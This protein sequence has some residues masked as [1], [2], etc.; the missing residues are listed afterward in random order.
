MRRTLICIILAVIFP[1]IDAPGQNRAAIDSLLRCLRTSS[2]DT[3]RVKIFLDLYYEFHRSNLDTAMEYAKKGKSLAEELGF[4]R[5]LSNATY[6]LGAGYNNLRN[7][8]L[9]ENEFLQVVKYAELLQ[10]TIELSVAYSGLA[11]VYLGK[12]EFDQAASAYLHALK[13]LSTTD[14]RNSQAR[15]LNELGSLYKKQLQFDKALTYYED[16]LHI[17]RDLKFQPGISSCLLNIGSVYIDLKE[18]QKALPYLTESLKIKKETGDRLGEGRC[19][20]NI[21]NL[22]R[23]LRNFELAHKLYTESL[24]LLEAVINPQEI[25]RVQYNLSLNEVQRGDFE[26][27]L[28]YGKAGLAQ[29][30]VNRDLD[31]NIKCRTLLADTYA[32]LNKTD[33]AYEHARM[34]KILSDSLY[35]EKIIELSTELDAKYQNEKKQKE[36]VDL[37]SKNQ[38]NAL[39]LQK[40][41]NE[42]NYLIVLTLLAIFLGFVIWSRYRIKV[43]S[44]EKLKELD[45]AKSHFFANI[46]HEFRTPLTLILGSAKD[47]LLRSKSDE[48]YSGLVTLQRNASRLQQLIEQLL[49]LSKL[50]GN[51]LKLNVEPSN[52]GNFLRAITSSFTSW[53]AQKNIRLNIHVPQE[54][55]IAYFDQDI[56]EKIVYNLLSNA[57]KFTPEH[58]QVSLSASWTTVALHIRITDSGPGIPPATKERIFERF[59][60]LDDSNT[61]MQEGSGIGLAL[62]KELVSLHHGQVLVESERG[63][64]ATFLITI[65]IQE[66]EYSP[67]ESALVHHEN[68]GIPVLMESNSAQTYPKNLEPAAENPIILIVED[69]IDLSHFIGDHLPEYSIILAG[70]GVDGLKK[71]IQHVPDLII[72]DV[73]MPEMDGVELCQRLKEEEKTS[74]IPVILLTAKADIDSRMEGLVTGA[75]DYMTKPF[76]ARE[77]QIRVANLIHQREKLRARFSRTVV[78]KPKDIAITPPD[79]GFLAKV[80][81]IIENHLSDSEFTVEEFQKEVGMSRMQLHRKLK[82][83]TGHSAG[84]FMRIQRLVR[85]S[86]LLSRTSSNISEVCYQT[87]FTSLSYFAKCFKKQF[88]TT[89][90]AYASDHSHLF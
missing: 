48:D 63:E 58:G 44:N 84:D 52:P 46:S 55:I 81:A 88:G 41:E 57:I 87:G 19:L 53:A 79:E 45:R 18:Y 82:A 65:P 40:R 77:L 73:M 68:A 22:Q 36:I 29:S 47:L 64:G 24:K 11:R 51:K 72:S 62:V 2:P 27:A 75:D 33:S 30:Q 4:I 28:L 89:P 78:L 15:I 12:N 49:D 37:S 13:L 16:A 67:S 76:D 8:D 59:Y 1:G 3:F 23:E 61:R 26:K 83:L 86:D 85:A 25:N 60:Q 32:A 43:R 35:N 80:M 74:H 42:R 70:N 31:M 56:V 71:S 6:R 34:S 38:L 90:K 20:L 50:E 66:K 54:N 10:D 7:F 21:G 17:V 39:Q 14:D 69:N 5:G 9:A